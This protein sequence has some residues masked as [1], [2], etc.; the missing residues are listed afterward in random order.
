MDFY[1]RTLLGPFGR[2][3]VTTPVGLIGLS[4]GGPI[5]AEFVAHHRERVS[6]L[7]LFVPAGL[8]FARTDSNASSA[9]NKL[10][11]R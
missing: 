5:I 3:N 4:M 2:V 8:D 6:R 11:A 7:F 9:L 10:K 1:D